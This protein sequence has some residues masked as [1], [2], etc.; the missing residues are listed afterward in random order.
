M[1]DI[2]KFRLVWPTRPFRGVRGIDAWGGG[3]F[4][5]PRVKSKGGERITYG[6]KGLDLTAKPDDGLVYPCDAKVIR[7]GRAY[8]DEDLGSLHLRATGEL[9]PLRIKFLYVGPRVMLKVGSEGKKGTVLGYVQDRADMAF[10]HDPSRGPMTNHVHIELWWEAHGE[11]PVLLDPGK[12]LDGPMIKG[13]V[14]NNAS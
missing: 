2:P 3:G 1:S 9:A 10:R 6:H 7:I 13:R 12:Y 5:A 14:W 8:R 4:N 11:E